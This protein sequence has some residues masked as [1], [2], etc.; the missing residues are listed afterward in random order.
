MLAPMQQRQL[1]PFE[2]VE[3]GPAAPGQRDSANPLTF[4]RPVGEAEQEAVSPGP[5]TNSR[6][7]DPRFMRLTV[8]AFPAQQVGGASACM[9]PG[10]AYGR[11]VKIATSWLGVDCTMLSLPH[12]AL[13]QCP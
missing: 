6:N 3:L 8:K 1:D 10:S 4:P 11:A 7:C 9:T 5:P 13:H 12:Q 2:M